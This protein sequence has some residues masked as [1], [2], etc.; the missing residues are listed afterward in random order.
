[1]AKI[2]G[3]KDLDF[4]ILMSFDDKELGKICQINKYINSLCKDNIFWLNRIQ[5]KFGRSVEDIKAITKFLKIDT[6]YRLIYGL[7]KK[8]KFLKTFFVK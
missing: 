1:M 3:I 2:T 4:K 7:K 8:I 5:L 6:T